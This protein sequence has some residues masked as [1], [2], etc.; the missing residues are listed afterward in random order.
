[1]IRARFAFFSA[2]VCAALSMSSGCYLWTGPL[3]AFWLEDSNEAKPESCWTVE[4][5]FYSLAGEDSGDWG[6]YVHLCCDGAEVVPAGAKCSPEDSLTIGWVAYESG[7]GQYVVEGF[8]S[9]AS[10]V[11]ID[12]L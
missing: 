7:D 9:L 10:V 5:R 4:S 3:P 11:D 2:A 8:D 6:A 12:M 1:M